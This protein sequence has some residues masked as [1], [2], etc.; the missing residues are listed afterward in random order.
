MITHPAGACAPLS[1]AAV[2]ARQEV[3]FA[4]GTVLWL[5][6]VDGAGGARDPFARLIPLP[7]GATALVDLRQLL[8]V[9]GYQL[10]CATARDTSTAVFHGL[11]HR[12]QSAGQL[13]QSAGVACA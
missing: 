7:D 4:D 9:L 8:P 5:H 1:A 13:L 2:P 10:P 3:T 6:G 12:F 11:R